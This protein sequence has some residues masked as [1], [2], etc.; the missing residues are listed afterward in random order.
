MPICT[1]WTRMPKDHASR[2]E[3]ACIPGNTAALRLLAT[4]LLK[5]ETHGSARSVTVVTYETDRI[6]RKLEVDDKNR[7]QALLRG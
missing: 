3:A 5:D 1:C 7:G 4:G 2:D 6:G